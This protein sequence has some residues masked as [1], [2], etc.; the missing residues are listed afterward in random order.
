LL[1]ENIKTKEPR[2]LFPLLAKI[3][4]RLVELGFN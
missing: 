1:N 3:V 2:M 4:Q